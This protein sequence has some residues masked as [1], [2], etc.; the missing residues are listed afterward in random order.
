MWTEFI[1]RRIW[2]SGRFFCTGDCIFGLHNG[3]KISLLNDLIL[4]SQGNFFIQM[5]I[6]SNV[7]FRWWYKFSLRSHYCKYK[8]VYRSKKASLTATEMASIVGVWRSGV[9]KETVRYT[10]SPQPVCCS[11]PLRVADTVA[12][13]PLCPAG[14]VLQGFCSRQENLLFTAR[15]GWENAYR[16]GVAIITNRQWSGVEARAEHKASVWSGKSGDPRREARCLWA[17]LD[18]Q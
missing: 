1:W 9:H 8:L 13:H 18:L 12:V 7:S 17:S 10:R 5:A 2:T 6:F 3:G 15:K 14:C 16:I 4:V 11:G